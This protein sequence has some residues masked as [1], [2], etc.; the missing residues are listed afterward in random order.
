M[1]RATVTRQSK[2]SE[3]VIQR[4]LWPGTSRP[5]K[6]RWDLQGEGKGGVF[7]GE[8]KESRDTSLAWIMRTLPKA[9]QQLRDATAGLDAG[10]LFVALHQV[11]SSAWAI[12]V[13]SEDGH[14]GPYTPEEFKA[15]WLEV[16]A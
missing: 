4:R 10:G 11:H 1:N 12:F 14:D 15:R 2:S 7:Y 13:V 9:A 3:N 8:V 6:E 5:W 16:P